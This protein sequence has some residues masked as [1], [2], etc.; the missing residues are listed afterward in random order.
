MKAKS[1]YRTVLAG[2]AAAVALGAL[3]LGGAIAQ[4]VIKIGV[5]GPITGEAAAD[6]QEMER[7]VRLAV[8]EANANGGVAG[9]TFEVVTGDTEDQSAAAVMSAVERVAREDDLHA[10]L[11]GYAS[12][13]NFEIEYLAEMEMPYLVAGQS[14]Q[15]RDIISPNPEDYPTIWSYTPNYDAYETA[16]PIVLGEIEEKH[17][18][19]FENRTVAL[20]TSDNA[21][22]MSIYE[23]LKKSFDEAGWTVVFDETL[24]F[25]EIGDWR[26]TLSRV[27]QAEPDVIVNADFLP[28]NGA[29]FM[30]QF[31]ADPIDSLVFIQYAPSV[32]EF[33]ELTKDDST[34]VIYNILGAPVATE[35]NPRALEIMDKF[36][37][38]WGVESGMYGV[39]L[40]EMTQLYFDALKEVGDPTDHVAIGE[41]IGRT[42]K[43]TASGRLVFDQETHLAMQGEDYF[44]IQFLQLWDGERH[45]FYPEKYATSEFR[46]PPWMSEAND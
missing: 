14:Q 26:S 3:P 16:L 32:P 13:T 35:A 34:G 29:R 43:Q 9:Y 44:P 31:M 40:Y 27:R 39:A 37:E 41:A 25:G 4:E 46:I 19:D 30:S 1:G 24:P 21:Y 36:E 10:M 5:L 6:G 33:L 22:S 2:L 8:E 17:G 15:T 12:N 18:L 45:L 20:I 11:T 38:R 23:G 7:G 28:G 42:D